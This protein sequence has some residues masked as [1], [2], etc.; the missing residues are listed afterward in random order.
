MTAIE[1][2]QSPQ[3]WRTHDELSLTPILAAALTDLQE[4]GYHGTTVRRIAAGVGL[5]MPSLYYHYGNKE[6]ILFALLDIAMDDL[7][8]HIRGGLDEAGDDTRTKLINFVTAV[9]LHNTR[10]RDLA[11]LHDEFRFLGPEFLARYLAKRGVVDQTL[12]DLLREGVDNG[13]FDLD[14]DAPFTSRVILGMLRGIIDWYSEDGPLRAEDIAARYTK[15]VMRL[16]DA[17][18]SSPS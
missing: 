1:M 8:A 2:S 7:L 18:G 6:G 13:I 4:L 10:R 16:V 12:V 9:A 17:A 11:R 14:E 5:T 3:G 15:S